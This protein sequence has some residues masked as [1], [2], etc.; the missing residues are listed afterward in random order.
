MPIKYV[1]QANL[2]RVITKMKALVATK[3]DSGHSHSAA[4]QSAAGYMSVAD[5]KKLDGI[6]TGA[7]KIA[8]DTDL[9]STSTNPVQNKVINSALAGKAN[10]S[11][12]HG[13]SDVSGLQSALNGKAASDHSHSAA[14]TGAAGL[15]SAADKKKLDGIAAGANKT[16]VD[17]ALSSSSTNPVQNK[18]VNTAL[19][20]KADKENGFFYIVGSGDTAGTWLADSDDISEYFDGL[21]ILYKV[22]VEGISGT[23]TLNINGLGAVTVVR[24]ASTAISTAFPVNSVVLLTYTTDDGTSYWKVADYDSDT[25]TTTSTTNKTDTKLFLA[26]ATTQGSGK[27]TYSNKN[28]YIGTDNCL[29]SNGAKTLTASDVVVATTDQI[30]EIWN[31]A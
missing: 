18:V 29:Y 19:A 17:S 31:N 25:K 6:A 7:T 3:A 13:I 4:T 12:S 5:K 2:A 21:T 8:V 15:M 16:T 10:S 23:T 22:P 14:T 9:S 11:H 1:S 24:N 28:C 27:T 30:D 26:G 20:G